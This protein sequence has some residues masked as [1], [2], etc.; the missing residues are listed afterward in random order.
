MKA[1]CFFISLLVSTYI[2][3]AREIA[4]VDS[5]FYKPDNSRIRYTGRFDFSNKEKPKF[6]A[7]GA[8]ITIRFRGSYLQLTL[9]DEIR[10]GKSH[11]YIEL[12]IDNEP[13]SRIQTL[14]ANNKILAASGLHNGIHTAVITKDTE[15]EIGYLELIGI[16]CEKLLTAPKLPK[17]KFE[18]I[19]NSITC[20]MGNDSKTIPCNSREWYDQHNAY[21]AFGPITARNLNAQ[22]QLS[23]VSGIGLIKSCCNKKTVMPQVFDK[24][25]MADNTIAWDFKKYQPT[26]TFI[27]LGQNDGIQDSISFCTAYVNFVNKIRNY[28]PK[29]KFILL[30]SPMGDSI[31]TT[32]LTS[33]LKGIKNELNSS[34]DSEVDV[35]CFKKRY[36]K[37]CD[38]HPTMEEHI[39]IATE[40]TKFI[41]RKLGW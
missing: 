9:N 32:V 12:K 29:T 22:W 8:Y 18:F 13:S 35:Y 26:V 7:P 19:G 30:T 37:G 38:A 24:I 3:S 34:G 33:Y 5:N 1:A 36:Y 2:V 11:N 4:S 39:E 6:W 23:S 10:W 41:K 20:G 28:Y 21:K 15:A 14:S 27:C 25:N 17:I 31:H 40:L 16:T